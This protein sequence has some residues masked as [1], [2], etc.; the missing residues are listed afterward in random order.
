M[1]RIISALVLV[2]AASIGGAGCSG[3]DDD[4]NN[5]TAGKGNSAGT[6]ATGDGGTPATNNGGAP[7]AMAGMP[8]TNNGGEPSTN[9]GAAS[10]GNV[11]CD[12]T[13]DGVCQNPID[14]PFVVDGTAR[15]TA[16]ECG[17]GCVISSD[18]NCSRDCILDKLDMSSDCAQ[19]YAG[20]V[21]CAI[22]NCIA[23]C[24]QDSEA[25]ACK[26]CQVDKGCRAAFNECS[27]LPD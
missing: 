25:V 24:L 5:G 20:A 3:D 13:E 8:A 9:G 15:T 21:A 18:E 7:A 27:G 23:Q 12:P 4:S 26:Q 19:C 14:C 2:T 1:K 16:G 22:K 10:S 11:M 6:H 17:M